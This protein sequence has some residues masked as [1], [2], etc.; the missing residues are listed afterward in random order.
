[1]R[2]ALFALMLA[3]LPLSACSTMMADD[4]GALTPDAGLAVRHNITAQIVNPN[5]PNGKGAFVTDGERVYKALDR[6]RKGTVIPPS[7][8]STSRSGGGGADASNDKPAESSPAT[9]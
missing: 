6:Y 1:M 2:I 3:A 9:P 5:A 7:S 4:E 8:A